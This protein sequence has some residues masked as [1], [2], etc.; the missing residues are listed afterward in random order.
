MIHFVISKFILEKE[1]MVAAI[2]D[3]NFFQPFHLFSVKKSDLILIFFVL[4]TII[5]TR[6]IIFIVSW[7]NANYIYAVD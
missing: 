2:T 4:L 6:I 3:C 1:R 7:I 5:F